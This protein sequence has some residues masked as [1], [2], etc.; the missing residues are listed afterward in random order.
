LD[1]QGGDLAAF[2]R[3]DEIERVA[4]DHDVGTVTE[5]Q[6]RTQK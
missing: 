4:F 5:W 1:L 3:E 6:E 2:K